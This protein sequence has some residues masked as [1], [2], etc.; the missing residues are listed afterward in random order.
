MSVSCHTDVHE[1]MHKPNDN[2][3]TFHHRLTSVLL[4]LANNNCMGDISS[5]CCVGQVAVK[6]QTD[7]SI[8]SS[9]YYVGFIISL[10][11][12]QQ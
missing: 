2:G 5:F 10:C 6:R 7:N 9:Y 1:H 8:C 11:S 12:L 4:Y 3:E